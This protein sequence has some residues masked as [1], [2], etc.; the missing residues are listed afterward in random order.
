MLPPTPTKMGHLSFYCPPIQP[1]FS[2]PALAARASP[3]APLSRARAPFYSSGARARGRRAGLT[4]RETYRGAAWSSQ[5]DGGRIVPPLELSFCDQ[6][7]RSPKKRLE[8]RS[9][10]HFKRGKRDPHPPTLHPAHKQHVHRLSAPRRE[11]RLCSSSWWTVGRSSFFGRHRRRGKALLSICRLDESPFV[12]WTIRSSER[13]GLS[14]FFARKPPAFSHTPFHLFAPSILIRS[15]TGWR[16]RPTELKT[17]QNTTKQQNPRTAERP[18]P[19][20]C[21]C[22]PPAIQAIS[23]ERERERANV[24]KSHFD[25]SLA[26]DERT[27]SPPYWFLTF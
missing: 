26:G 9:A 16:P 7:Q 3:P 22:C 15:R 24:R 27:V 10:P 12:D 6:N 20:R 21:A 18:E 14:L 19:L 8:K 1:P 2:S 4:S 13:G 11:P 23:R 17:K 25:H 5:K